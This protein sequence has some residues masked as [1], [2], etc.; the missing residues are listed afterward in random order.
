MA[1]PLNEKTS[2]TRRPARDRLLSAADELFYGHGINVVGIDR[3]IEKAGVAKASLYE[4]FDGKEDLIR[5]YVQA[6]DERRRARILQRI[7]PL[8]NPKDK[9]LAVFDILS[10]LASRPDFRGCAF[11]RAGAESTP[12][13]TVR[14]ACEDAREWMQGSS[15]CSTTAPRCRRNS[16][17]V[18]RRSPPRALLRGCCWTPLR[19]HAERE[20]SETFRPHRHRRAWRP[21][22]LGATSTRLRRRWPGR[23]VGAPTITSQRP[24]PRPLVSARGVFEPR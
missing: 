18:Q 22:M 6:R 2:S 7:E 9:A 21:F 24:P 8:K 4:C 14:S 23:R 19:K 10:E 13:S 17:G 15:R 1:K 12:E 3:V 11:I 16:V 5:S 20:T